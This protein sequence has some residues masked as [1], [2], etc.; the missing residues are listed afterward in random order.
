MALYKY[1]YREPI[2]IE[3]IIDQTVKVK[4]SSGNFRHFSELGYLLRKLERRNTN[5]Q[6][7]DVKIEHL[8]PS[9]NVRVNCVCDKCGSNFDKRVY[10]RTD[11]CNHCRAVKSAIGNT[12]GRFTKGS[13][14]PSMQGENHPRW[15]PNK[16]EKRK[17]THECNKVTKQFDLSVLPNSDKP[18][19]LCG[20]E[21]VYQ[22]DH[23]IPIQYG[24]ENDISPE[25][26]GHINNLQFIPW[27]ENNSKRDKLL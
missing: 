4:I 12:N 11:F 17:Y 3:M 15:N 2:E 6:T 26:I 25:I 8:K 27:E 5:A 14:V 21:G 18:R 24:F 10:Q 13:T 1:H 20:I 9:S 7:I 19:G 23:I 22:L 16:S